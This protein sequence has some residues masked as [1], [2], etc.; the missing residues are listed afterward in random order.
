M[1]F[2][3]I[4]ELSAWIKII[5]ALAAFLGTILW[6]G[7]RSIRWYDKVNDFIGNNEEKIK[8]LNDKYFKIAERVN[9]CERDILRIDSIC[10]ERCSNVKDQLKS[11]SD[12][13]SVLKGKIEELSSEIQILSNQSL[14]KGEVIKYLL[15]PDKR[16]GL[17]RFFK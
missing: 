14:E 2:P 16:T 15:N 4:K 13:S 10:S 5:A 8:E 11:A 9:K 1:N 12:D 6:Y 3:D 7:Y 17:K